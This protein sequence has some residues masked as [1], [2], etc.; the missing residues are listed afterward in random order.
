[1]T[2][3]ILVKNTYLISDF[4]YSY[5]TISFF[6]RLIIFFSSLEIYDCDIPSISATSF[7]VSSVPSSLLS[8][9]R[10]STICLSR[11]V[12]RL[13]ALLSSFFSTSSS[14]SLYMT[15]S[16]VQSISER[17]SSF[18]SQSTFNGSSMET[19]MR[20]LLFLLRYISI[21]FSIHLDAYVASLM[22]LPES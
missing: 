1:M 9:K 13:I 15:S 21:S 7:C 4:I 11:S 3:F 2:A 19:S 12:R 14:I 6:R 18:P 5:L 22:F 20:V 8:P 16:S 17:R 10:R